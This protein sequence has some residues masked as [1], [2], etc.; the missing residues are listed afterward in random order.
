VVVAAAVTA[1]AAAASPEQQHQQQQEG[2]L[3]ALVASVK[4]QFQKLDGLW[5]K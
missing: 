2:F 3:S 4:S 5:D 1:A